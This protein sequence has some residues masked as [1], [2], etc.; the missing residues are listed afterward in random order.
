[1]ETWGEKQ[2]RQQHRGKPDGK[3]QRGGEGGRDEDR[4]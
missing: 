2:E 4:D 3:R 1:M